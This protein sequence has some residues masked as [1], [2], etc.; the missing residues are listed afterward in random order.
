LQLRKVV[1]VFDRSII[2]RLRRAP[3]ADTQ[4]FALL[5]GIESM[6][7]GMLVTVMPLS[8]YRAF[9][10]TGTVSLIYLTVGVISLTTGLMLPRMGRHIPRRWM[11]TMGAGLYVLGNSLAIAGGN[12]LAAGLL[13]NAIATVTVFIC[14]NAYVLDYIAKVEL[15]RSETLRMFYS[16][17]AW[18]IGPVTGV[19]LLDWWR[20]APFAL[21]IVAAFVLLAVFWKMRLGNGKIIAKARKPAANPLA[22]IGRF[23]AQPRLIAG[24]LFAVIRSCG[25]WVYVVYMPIFAVEA[26]LGD[27]IGGTLLSMTNAVLFTTPLML[28]WMQRRTIR[29][30]VRI[31]FF[32]CGTTFVLAT[33]AASQPYAALGILFIGSSFLILLDIAG[34]LPFLLA[35][36]PSERTEMS[37]VYSSFRDVSGIATPGIAW[38]VLLAFPLSGVFAAIG[39]TLFAAWAL[40]GKQH[41]QIGIR[42]SDR[43][44]HGLTKITTPAE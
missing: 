20:P 14:L 29:T 31:G 39:V 21:S 25:W 33:L 5:S 4:R 9:P 41:P 34:G 23:F 43:V 17:L 42:A 10:D 1:K 36:K 13:C 22:F 11:F 3:V 12:L 37:A 24:W 35:V 6:V 16:A 38:L 2:L 19:W 15:G 26:G 30:T 7:R 27:K 8:V 28:R 32:A 18:T 44:R 40:A